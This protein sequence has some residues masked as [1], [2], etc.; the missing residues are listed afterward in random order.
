[1]T[2]QHGRRQ[3]RSMLVLQCR[4]RQRKMTDGLAHCELADQKWQAGSDALCTQHAH[5]DAPTDEHHHRARGREH[6]AAKSVGWQRRCARNRTHHRAPQPGR[7]DG[8]RQHGPETTVSDR[9]SGTHLAE[10][11]GVTAARAVCSIPSRFSASDCRERGRPKRRHGTPRRAT[12]R[13]T[14]F[15]SGS[16][17]TLHESTTGGSSGGCRSHA[18]QRRRR[19]SGGL[20]PGRA[21]DGGGSGVT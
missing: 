17:W 10:S 19:M 4:T 14:G 13:S 15:P 5:H 3:E 8:C 1:M 2:R 7:K 20:W 16:G 11:G 6:A 9:V 12:R 21:A 18:G